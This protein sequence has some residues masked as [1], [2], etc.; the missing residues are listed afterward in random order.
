VQWQHTFAGQHETLLNVWPEGACE[1]YRAVVASLFSPQAVRYRRER[2][3][4]IGRARMAVGFLRLVRA[5]ASGVIHT[6]DPVAPRRDVMVVSATWGLGPTVAQGAAPVDRFELSREPAPRVLH[7]SIAR[8]EARLE[9]TPGKQGGTHLV[10]VE[11]AEQ[12]VPSVDD[13][14]LAELGR[15]ALRIERHLGQH[16]EIEWAIGE[17]RRPVI[18]Q[19]RGLRTLDSPAERE[20]EALRLSQLLSGRPALIRGQGVIACRGVGAGP[21]VVVR[22]AE[23]LAGFPQGAVLVAHAAAPALSPLLPR[24]SAVITNVGSSTGHLAA[25][26]REDRV[27]M[28]VGVTDATERLAPGSEVTVDAEENVVYAGVVDELVRFHLREPPQEAEFEEFRLLR[29]LLRRVAPLHLS[30]PLAEGFHASACTSYHDVVRYAHEMAVRQLTEMPGLRQSDRRRCVRRLSLKVPM[31]LD[32]LDLGGGLDEAATPDPLPPERVRSAPL[33]A[34]LEGLTAPG[35]WRT[36]PVDLDMESLLASA[37]R[38]SSLDGSAT[39]TVRPNLAVITRDY[40]NLHLRLGYHFNLIDCHL[41]D[42]T[43]SNYIYFRF[44]GGVTD[45][46]RRSR[47]ARLLATILKEYDFAV[48]TKGDLVIGRIRDLPRDSAAERLQMA[49]RL[50]GYSR[51]LDVL[52]RD[53]TTVRECAR[54]FVGRPL[55]VID[56]APEAARAEPS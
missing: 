11:A 7:R 15:L 28:L 41:S 33:R 56:A 37:T 18:L 42:E 51:Q 29:R 12:E 23:D 46:S 16:Q 38:F 22:S 21:V 3:L 39:A 24:A 52:M 30:D 19:A 47:R 10:A 2:G 35:T 43:S 32:L 8:K 55:G 27:P 31:D 6:V 44:H 34:L 17:D 20:A 13:E 50:I 49:G 53:E 5:R 14:A 4:P 9:A 40:L 48:E 45:I 1:A 26:A 36:E 25:V 54:E